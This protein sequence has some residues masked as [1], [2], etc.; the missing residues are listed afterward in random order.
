MYLRLY[1]LKKA[2]MYLKFDTVQYEF[3]RFLAKVKMRNV[4][5]ALD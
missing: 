3:C 1:E 4:I 2:N 5:V